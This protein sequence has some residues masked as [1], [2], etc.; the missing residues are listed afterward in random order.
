MIHKLNVLAQNHQKEALL[1]HLLILVLIIVI[2]FEGFLCKPLR[3]LSQLLGHL[4]VSAFCRTG[5]G[6]DPCH[7]ELELLVL[8]I[9]VRNIYDA[10][11]LLDTLFQSEAARSEV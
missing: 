6:A 10:R 8:A 3:L 1:F 2:A 4:L 5:Q 11:G 7:L 9:L